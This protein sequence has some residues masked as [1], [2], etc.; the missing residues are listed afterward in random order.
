MIEK[1]TARIES[2]LPILVE[3]PEDMPSEACALIHQFRRSRGFLPDI[4]CLP[5]SECE[6]NVDR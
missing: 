3:T 2:L 1:D 6:K 5:C 4:A